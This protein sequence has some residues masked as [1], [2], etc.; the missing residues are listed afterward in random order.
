[1]VSSRI[2][3]AAASHVARAV[4]TI[5]ARNSLL[6]L[7]ADTGSHTCSDKPGAR[8]AHQG[9]VWGPWPCSL[10]RAPGASHRRTG[11][12]AHGHPAPRAE[13]GSVPRG[14]PRRVCKAARGPFPSPQGS[15]QD[16]TRSNTYPASDCRPGAALVRG[17]G[18]PGRSH[19]LLVTCLV[20]RGHLPAHQTAAMVSDAPSGGRCGGGTEHSPQGHT[21]GSRRNRG[22]RE[23]DAAI[24]RG[25]GP[26]AR[27]GWQGGRG[28]GR[29]GACAA[30]PLGIAVG[31]LSSA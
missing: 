1:M 9:V 23:A 13:S 2:G 7:S 29:R 4:R 25:W 17:G 5:A 19:E 28:R 30:Q 6:F 24:T 8:S 10:T 31:A 26:R 15:D 27:L 14:S 3:S 20:R 16:G 22:L 12:G 18:V 11:A 21:G